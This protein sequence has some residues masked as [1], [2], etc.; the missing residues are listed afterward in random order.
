MITVVVVVVVVMD[1]DVAAATA[2]VTATAAA[3]AVTVA[4][5]MGVSVAGTVAQHSVRTGHTHNLRSSVRTYARYGVHT[6]A[7]SS[8]YSSGTIHNKTRHGWQ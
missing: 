1:Y 4:V 5:V 8:T 3:V 6:S 7:Y 2:T